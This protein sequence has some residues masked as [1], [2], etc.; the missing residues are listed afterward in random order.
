MSSSTAA[1]EAV[2]RAKAIAARLSGTVVTSTMP[3]SMPT[4]ASTA[5]KDGEN[6]AGKRKRWGVMPEAAGAANGAGA[7]A[8]ALP[9]LSEAALEA[10]KKQKLATEP[11]E[12]RL[13]VSSTRSEK[14]ISHFV[15]FLTP[16]LHD[17]VEAI[18]KEAAEKPQ[19]EQ[20]PQA[21]QKDAK[22]SKLFAIELRGR[23]SLAKPPL[24]GMPEEPLHIMLL[25]LPDAITRA[26]PIV[27]GLL[28]DAENAPLE[29]PL[30]ESEEQRLQ[31]LLSYEGALTV[32]PTSS[33]RNG[34]GHHSTSAYR[35][36]SV[37]MLIGQANMSPEDAIAL[38]Q[39]GGGA[40]L[41]E[42]VGVPNGIVGFIIGRGGENIAS[43]QA[44][45]GCKVQIQKE[46]EL[47]PGQTQRLITLQAMR[48][49]SIDECRVL[50]ENMVQE[51][52]QA[53]G[54]GPGG[55]GGSGGGG[56]KE[57]RVQDA[58]AV[59]HELVQVEIPD[60][61]VGL[62]IGK[63]G[64]TI[65]S[66]QEQSGASIQVPQAGNADNP[67]V[68][69]VSITHPTEQGA[70]FAKQLIEDLLK[71]KPSYA[72][73]GGGGGGGHHQGQVTVQVP[74]SNQL[75]ELSVICSESLHSIPVFRAVSCPFSLF[76]TAD[77]R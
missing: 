1:A 56:P 39:G 45:T 16:K 19:L 33:T 40:G 74:V 38:V 50:I 2:A 71:S 23:G 36:A 27:E 59:G 67:S 70:N 30:P 24:P 42:Q 32:L 6:P 68:R 4:I 58:L 20:A 46:H 53:S 57:V 21:K 12:K 77:S 61:D 55:G 44:R 63:M 54:R 47:Q 25:G 73:G 9:G 18:N 66:I 28:F 76:F 69:T 35:P 22:S 8:T 65:K 11:T 64:S 48:Q 14:P 10:A 17:I 34:H 31:Q 49:E 75:D 41:E 29:Q 15:A 26:E 51:R 7:V 5:G 37:A 13:W 60:A 72:G 52:V 62:I 43:M 3:A